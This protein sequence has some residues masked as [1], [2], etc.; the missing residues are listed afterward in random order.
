MA[1]GTIDYFLDPI[2]LFSDTIELRLII[3]VGLITT[4]LHTQRQM[5][6]WIDSDSLASFLKERCVL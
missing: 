1:E 5:S 2:L 4:L 3:R 6:F